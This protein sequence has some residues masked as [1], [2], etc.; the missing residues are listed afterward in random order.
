MEEAV[1]HSPGE[2]G[3]F[4]VLPKLDSLQEMFLLIILY[5]YYSTLNIIS[6]D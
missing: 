3:G 1:P 6:L 2:V 5:L 4:R